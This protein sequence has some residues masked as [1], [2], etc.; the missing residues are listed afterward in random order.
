MKRNL[1]ILVAGLGVTAAALWFKQAPSDLAPPES[2]AKEQVPPVLEAN[3]ELH[4]SQMPSKQSVVASRQYVEDLEQMLQAAVEM[5][6][7]AEEALITSEDELEELEAFV[8]EIKRRGEDPMDYA[9]EGM[10]QLQ[11]AFNRYQDAA[12]AL[13]QAEVQEKSAR[14]ALAAEQA[15]L[16][17]PDANGAER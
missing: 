11:P 17:M 16:N 6:S 10:Y 13:E 15:K 1:L 9:E 4:E 3:R 12:A 8:E 7:E 5:R 2:G 14:A